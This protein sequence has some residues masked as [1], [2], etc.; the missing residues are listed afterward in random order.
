MHRALPVLALLLTYL[1]LSA[2]VGVPNLIIGLMIAIGVLGL[3]RPKRLPVNW[4]RLPSAFAALLRFMIALIRNVII[5]GL[6]VTRIVLHPKLPIKPGIIA[7]PPECD[8]EIGR[9]I[10][11]HAISL[12]PGELLIEMGED[13]TMYI[14]SLDVVETERLVQKAQEQRRGLIKQIFD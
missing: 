7:A 2:S 11:A 5:S 4:T 8:N 13:G 3:L 12:T 1:A 10:G 6:Q 9:A 14:H